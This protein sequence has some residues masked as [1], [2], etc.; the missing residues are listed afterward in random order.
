MAIHQLFYNTLGS[1]SYVF[2]DGTAAFF[3]D[4]S[5]HTGIEQ[6]IS[7]LKDEISKRHP[8]LYQIPG[9]E[10]LDTD[11]IDPVEEEI[12][13]RV[14]AAVASIVEPVAATTVGVASSATITG[15]KLSNSK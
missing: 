6:E 5:Y 12:Q 2:K 10:T 14:N 9:Q 15:A 3:K 11:A 4:G 7:E 13:R 1:T 8:Y